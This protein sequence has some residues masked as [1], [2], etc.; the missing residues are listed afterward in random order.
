MSMVMW[1]LVM[2]KTTEIKTKEIDEK[3]DAIPMRITRKGVV[4]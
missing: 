4:R 2:G 3:D 1:L